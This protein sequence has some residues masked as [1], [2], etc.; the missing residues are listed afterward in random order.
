MGAGTPVA[1][2]EPVVFVSVP[3]WKQVILKLRSDIVMMLWLPAED[4]VPLLLFCQCIRAGLSH[5]CH[6]CPSD[7]VAGGCKA[8]TS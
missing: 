6:L 2:F 8:Q 4:R 3:C 5:G 7:I 1:L